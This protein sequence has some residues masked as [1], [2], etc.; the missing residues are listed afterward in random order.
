MRLVDG[1]LTYSQETNRYMG[2]ATITNH[3]FLP[4]VAC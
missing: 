3:P 1:E 2:N 4:T